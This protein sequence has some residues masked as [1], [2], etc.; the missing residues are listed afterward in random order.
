MKGTKYFD[1]Q[2]Q[3]K[4]IRELDSKQEKQYPSESKVDKSK[5]IKIFKEKWD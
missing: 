1:K 2:P 5:K 3:L 4:V